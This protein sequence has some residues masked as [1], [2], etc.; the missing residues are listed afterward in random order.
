M[1]D[2]RVVGD[3]NA[4]RIGRII[5][6]SEARAQWQSRPWCVSAYNTPTPGRI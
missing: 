1:I 2:L 4:S 3:P 5:P 6:F